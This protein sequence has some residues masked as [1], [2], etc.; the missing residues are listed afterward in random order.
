VRLFVAIDIPPEVKA[1]LRIFIEGL[2]PMAKLSWSQVDNLHVTT[3]FIGEWPQERLEELKETLAQVP[4]PGS[5]NL[6][7]R[8]LG[9]FPNSRNPRVFW[10][11]IDAGASLETLAGDLDRRLA[12]LGVPVERRE[13]HPHLTLA[14]RRD[15]V[16]LEKLREALERQQQGP[17][18]PDFGSFQASS[19]VLYLSAGGKYTKIEEFPLAA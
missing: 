1:R 13:F 9:W 14:R 3:K 10:A 5:V 6:A 11:G 2:R 8:G 16:P 18:Y 19:F 4:K 12:A 15:P 7:V 17:S